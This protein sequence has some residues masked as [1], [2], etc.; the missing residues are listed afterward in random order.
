M[1]SDTPSLLLVE[2][3]L[4]LAATL[5][6]ILSPMFRVIHVATGA[7]ALQTLRSEQ[8]SVLVLDI[9][10][11]DMSGTEVLRQLRK[12]GASLPVLML[13][14]QAEDAQVV[15]V[16]NAGADDY[17][18]K[19]FVP[20]VLLARL[21][22]LLRRGTNRHLPI[23]ELGEVT[24]DA[25]T[26]EVLISGELIM[27]R[28]KEFDILEVLMR[29]HDKVVTRDT[30][31]AS[32]WDQGAELFTNAIDVHIKHIRDKVDK[33]HA[34]SYIKTVHGMGY[35]FD[36]KEVVPTSSSSKTSPILGEEVEI[37]YGSTIAAVTAT[38]GGS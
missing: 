7:L 30:L 37:T 33:P 21:Q 13:T 26:R 14:A 23:L 12:T 22:A 29:N 38:A 34:T 35:K 31:L 32:A 4:P 3:S 18:T 16:L 28:R 20:E 6:D 19:P 8:W 17:L 10:L 11:P 27:L 36:T 2:D 15:S 1:K 25:A 5:A 24:L 9:G